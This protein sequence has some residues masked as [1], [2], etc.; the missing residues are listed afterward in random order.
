MKLPVSKEQLG[1][2]R[3]AFYLTFEPTPFGS[4]HTSENKRVPRKEAKEP[5]ME[6]CRWKN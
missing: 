4:K 1:L 6:I 3:Y 2:K 5:K